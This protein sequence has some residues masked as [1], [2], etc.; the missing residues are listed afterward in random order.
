MLPDDIFIDAL[1]N[2]LNIH[3]A[4][5]IEDAFGESEAVHT[6]LVNVLSNFDCHKIPNPQI[7]ERVIIDIAIL[8]FSQEAICCYCNLEYHLSKEGSRLCFILYM[9]MQAC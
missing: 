3:N 9:A 8:S 6:R 4:F 5:V 2:S 1:R 7:F